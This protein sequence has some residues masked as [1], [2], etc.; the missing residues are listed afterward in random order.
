MDETGPTSADYSETMS[1]DDNC[2]DVDGFDDN[3]LGDPKHFNNVFLD[4]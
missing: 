3:Q 2:H 1:Q 4:P